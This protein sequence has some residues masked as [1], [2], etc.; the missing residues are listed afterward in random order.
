ML[1]SSLIY[2][3]T[4]DTWTRV[5]ALNVA[6]SGPTA[7]VLRDGAV[8]VTGGTSTT[9]FMSPSVP[10]DSAELYVP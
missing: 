7:T 6:R 5:Q 9:P 3:P 1:A 10:L 4:K 8:L 2:D